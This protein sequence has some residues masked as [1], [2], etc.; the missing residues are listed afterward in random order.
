[1]LDEQEVRLILQVLKR[2]LEV[3]KA[4]GKPTA[5][6][7]ALEHRI[8]ELENGRV[9]MASVESRREAV[10]DCGPES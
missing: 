10:R 2:R 3:A 8:E 6:V 1:M 4:E 7:S 9:R 5:L